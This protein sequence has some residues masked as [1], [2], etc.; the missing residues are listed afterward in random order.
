M[1]PAGPVQK[2]PLGLVMNLVEAIGL[3]VTYAYADLVFVD[4]NAFLL[5]MDE[6]PEIIHLYFNTQSDPALRP[7]LVK[8]LADQARANGLRIV[9]QGLF[10]LEQQEGESIKVTF[11]PQSGNA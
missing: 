9:N 6:V 7:A 1:S 3:E 8:T 10:E 2:H 5:Q 11:L 4:N